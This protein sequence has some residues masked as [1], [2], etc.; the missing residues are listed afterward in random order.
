MS[1][2]SHASRGLVLIAAVLA[3]CAAPE[4]PKPAPAPSVVQG[5]GQRTLVVTE[6]NAGASVVLAS[7][8]AL[9]VRLP[10]DATAAFEWSLV[11]LKPGVLSAAGPKFERAPRNITADDGAGDSVWQFRPEAAG[12]VSLSF[13]LRRPHSLLPAVQTVRYDVTVR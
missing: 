11:D 6:A 2:L 7:A 1:H 13:E 4:G 8:Q 3:A 9:T 5:P 10:V 12:T